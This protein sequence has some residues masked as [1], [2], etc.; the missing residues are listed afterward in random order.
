MTEI[1]SEVNLEEKYVSYIMESFF[2]YYVIVNKGKIE[3]RSGI[4]RYSYGLWL[5]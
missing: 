3:K 5:C 2:F 4:S 1:L